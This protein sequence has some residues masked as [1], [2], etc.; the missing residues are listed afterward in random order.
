MFALILHP[1]LHADRHRLERRVVD[2]GGD[3][4][5]AAGDLVADELG[6]ELLA[7]GDGSISAVTTPWRAK[8]ICVRQRR[9]GENVRALRHAILPSLV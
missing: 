9:V 2:V 4:H 8:C 6:V 7:L 1:R 5:P 3:D